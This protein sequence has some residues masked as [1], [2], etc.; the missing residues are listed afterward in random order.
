MDVTARRPVFK[1]SRTAGM[2]QGTRETQHGSRE[3]RESR[4]RRKHRARECTRGTASTDIGR[5]MED[6]GQAGMSSSTQDC[7][8]VCRTR[9]T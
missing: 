1:R 5:G 9:F 4:A 3:A 8:T 6:G 2:L 7:S